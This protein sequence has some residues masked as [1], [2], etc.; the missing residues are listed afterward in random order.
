MFN[1]EDIPLYDTEI[2]YKYEKYY[3]IRKTLNKF[4]KGK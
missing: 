2:V 3:S 4:H 1:K